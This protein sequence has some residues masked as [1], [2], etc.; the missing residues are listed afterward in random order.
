MADVAHLFDEW[1]AALARG[2]RPDPL[3][4]IHRAGSGADDLATMMDRY[5]RARPRGEPDPETVELA[6]AWAAGE[7]PLVQLRARRGVRRDE[8]V[9]AVMAEFALAAEK[10]PVVKRYY[11]RLESGLLDPARVSQ[12]LLELLTRVLGASAASIA[13]WR[14]RPVDVSPAFRAAGAALRA[15]DALA[16]SARAPSAPSRPV[17]QD[18]DE[19][20]ALF[21]SGR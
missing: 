20:R 6:R 1:A 3:S 17:E 7:A 9:D 21:I 10:R 15:P 8:V 14:P 4:F 18:D 11:H 13:A 12:R 2:E 5:L 19:V 16:D